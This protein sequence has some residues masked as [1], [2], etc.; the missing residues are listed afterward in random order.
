VKPAP[1]KTTVTLASEPI[2]AAVGLLAVL[3]YPDPKQSIR[4]GRILK[5]W[6]DTNARYVGLERPHPKLSPARVE[7]RLRPIAERLDRRFEAARWAMMVATREGPIRL[8]F[9]GVEKATVRA[10][11]SRYSP[12]AQPSVIRDVWTATKPVLATTLAL[13]A[14]FENTPTLEDLCFSSA[15]VRPT[16]DGSDFLAWWLESWPQLEYH[17]ADRISFIMPDLISPEAQSSD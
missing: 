8:R 14:Q 10:L 16:I 6:H 5:A 11:A 2:A 9:G 15:W 17:A 1:A 13:L 7:E 4:A 12:A 3:T